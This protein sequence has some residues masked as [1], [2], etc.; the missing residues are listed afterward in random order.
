MIFVCLFNPIL[1]GIKIQLCVATKT[2]VLF[3]WRLLL[4]P[5]NLTSSVIATTVFS[6][7]TTR[8]GST[9]PEHLKKSVI[10]SQQ[11]MFDMCQQLSCV[12]KFGV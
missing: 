6:D 8:A 12:N 5:F 2:N 10:V 4:I 9:V 1:L 11:E 3:Y 7:D